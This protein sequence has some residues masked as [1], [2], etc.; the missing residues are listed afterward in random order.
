MSDSTVP[1]ATDPA[2]RPRVLVSNRQSEPI[3]EPGLAA[4]AE[5]VLAGEGLTDTEL[6]LSFV[7]AA[8]MAELHERFMHEA[9]PTDVLSFPLNEDGLLGDVVVCTDQASKNNPDLES[10]LRLLVA[11]GI[12]HLLGHDHEENEDRA[13]MWALQERYSGVRAP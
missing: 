7:H 12:L 9:W 4:L 1:R 3:D 13:R 10:E 8:E 5:Q 11:H 2:H 6:S